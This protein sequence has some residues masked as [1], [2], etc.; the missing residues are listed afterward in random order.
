MSDII[1]LSLKIFTQWTA[2]VE[3]FQQSS[4]TIVF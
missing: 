1:F 3:N 2:H 4:Q